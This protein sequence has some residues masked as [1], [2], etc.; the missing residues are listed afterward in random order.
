LD[1]RLGSGGAR[2]SWNELV[3]LLGMGAFP[4]VCPKGRQLGREP[5]FVVT[6]HQVAGDVEVLLP[7]GAP[8][9]T[10]TSASAGHPAQQNPMPG[11]AP[12]KVD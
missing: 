7:A 1:H 6:A 9:V 3:A 11:V 12:D 8:A 5:A 10:R 4:V 2:Q